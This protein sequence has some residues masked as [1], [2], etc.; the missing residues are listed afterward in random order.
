MIV[1]K[2]DTE[3]FLN[4]VEFEAFDGRSEKVGSHDICIEGPGLYIHLADRDYHYPAI[5][6]DVEK[7]KEM[8]SDIARAI[9]L[10]LVSSDVLVL[11]IHDGK[12]IHLDGM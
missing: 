8:L 3:I 1:V 12:I 5:Y 2:T 11:E 10:Y 6:C 4:V 7:A 9:S